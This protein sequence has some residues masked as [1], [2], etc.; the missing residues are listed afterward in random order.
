MYQSQFDVSVSPRKRIGTT[1]LNIPIKVIEAWALG[2]PIITTKHKV[3]LKYGIRDL[4]DI[5]M[6][7]MLKL[8]RIKRIKRY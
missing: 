8:F 1:E 4:K 3:F 6:I 2:I 7:S 5:I